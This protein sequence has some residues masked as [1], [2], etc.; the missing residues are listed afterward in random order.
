MAAFMAEFYWFASPYSPM[1]SLSPTLGLPLVCSLCSAERCLCLCH[2]C[3][4][5]AGNKVEKACD[6]AHITLNKNA[7][8]GDSSA[9]APGGVR[10]GERRALLVARGRRMTGHMATG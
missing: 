6:S 5:S 4:L 2:V 8:F 9:L 1:Q 7:V 3:V 10:I